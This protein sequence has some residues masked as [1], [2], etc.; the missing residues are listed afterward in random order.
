MNFSPLFLTLLAVE[1]FAL[2]GDGNF[3]LG[4]LVSAPANR[5]ETGIYSTSFL[6]PSR[7]FSSFT[8]E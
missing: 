7:F 1:N 6:S 2:P 8:F 4:G 3:P 5:G